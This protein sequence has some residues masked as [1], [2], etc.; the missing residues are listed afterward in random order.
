MASVTEHEPHGT[1][2]TKKATASGW[3]GSA[4]EYYDF[5]IYA[6][7]ASL[8][9]PQIFFPKSDPKANLKANVYWLVADESPAI[10]ERLQKLVDQVEQALP[11]VLS[12][13]N[14]IGS[15]LANSANLAS[16]LNVVALNAQPAL[17]NLAHLAV[18]LRGPGALGEWALGTNGQRNLDSTLENANLTLAHTDTNLTFLVENLARSLDNL[19]DITSNLNAQVEANTNLLGSI[20]KT[21]VDADDLVQGLKKHWF[22][23]SGFR[24]R[25]KEPPSTPSPALSPKKRGQQ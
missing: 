13:T 15:V 2:Q 20:S 7:A 5:F 10:T 16:N 1:H 18:Q 17:S 12:L 11:N 4:L 14:Q 24:S 3:I 8:I 9:F 22:L 23:R 25:T 21:V 19:A 6:T